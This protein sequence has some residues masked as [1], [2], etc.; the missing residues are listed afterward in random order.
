MSCR[1]I[2]MQSGWKATGGIAA[3]DGSGSR[4]IGDRCRLLKT[5]TPE[6]LY[7]ARA[8]FLGGSIRLPGVADV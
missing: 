4:G 6:P 8:F 5:E 1:H 2:L 3:R 7:A